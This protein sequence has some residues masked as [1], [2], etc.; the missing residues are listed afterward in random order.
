MIKKGFYENWFV[1]SGNPWFTRGANHNNGTDAGV[2]TF[3]N[4]NG[5]VATWIS[6]RENLL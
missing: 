3:N 1:H 4:A 2:F 5:S 6:F